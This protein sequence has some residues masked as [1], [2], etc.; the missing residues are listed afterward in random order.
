MYCIGKVLALGRQVRDPPWQPSLFLFS[1]CFS[2]EGEACNKTRVFYC[3]KIARNNNLYIIHTKLG[4]G[5]GHFTQ[6]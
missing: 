1:L 5:K 2:N 6:C 3:L 4:L